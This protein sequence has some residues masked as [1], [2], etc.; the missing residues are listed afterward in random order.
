MVFLLL[1]ALFWKI[2]FQVSIQNYSRRHI[3]AII[4]SDEHAINWTFTG[5]YGNPEVAKRRESW[6]LLKHL[7]TLSSQ[8][9][10]CCGDFNEITAVN[11]KYGGASRSNIQM[12]EFNLALEDCNLHDM[13][14]SGSR[15]TWSNKRRD[16]WFTKERLDRA[17]A[18][19]DFA[20]KFPQFAVE[21]LAS[22][23]S[24]HAP[25]FVSLQ[26]LNGGQMRIGRGFKYEAWWPKKRGF[27]QVVKR[28]WR[29]KSRCGDI[30]GALK[31]KITA[32]QF[33]CRKWRKT[34]ADPTAELIGQKTKE[35]GDL[36][37]EGEASDMEHLNHLQ[38]EVNEL[39]ESE[40]VKWRQRAKQ[41]WL[42]NGDKNS[43]F[44]TLQ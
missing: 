18:T 33:A 35:L 5:F 42:Q 27:S 4:F 24:D 39:L 41:E 32:S 8:A 7:A 40:D 9:W 22:R 16:F 38:L 21:V 25:L 15:F 19:V 12:E 2:P 26:G 30:W 43:S 1:I 17:V 3:N 10:L 29:E 28:V 44:F 6:A 36:Q 11:E 34:I 20:T 13:G 37:E 31:E 23:T 14:F